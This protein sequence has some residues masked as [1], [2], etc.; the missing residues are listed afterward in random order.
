MDRRNRLSDAGGLDVVG[1]EIEKILRGRPLT[2]REVLRAAG[3]GAVAAVLAACGLGRQS[4]K[5]TD[6]PGGAATA[7][8]SVNPGKVTLLM[9]SLGD[10]T[11]DI[12]FSSGAPG[13]QVFGT[14][15]FGPFIASNEALEQIPGIASE[16]TLSDDGLTF[17][18]TIRE[19][20]KFQDGREVTMDD[21]LWSFQ[22]MFAPEVAALAAEHTWATIAESLRIEMSGPREITFG[23]DSPETILL[24]KKLLF[25]AESG[26]VNIM[27]KRSKLH[28]PAEEAAFDAAPIGTGP[29]KLVEHDRGNR[30][31]F[32]RF[33][34]YFFQPKYGA[35]EDRRV[36]FQRLEL[37]AVP[38]QSTRLAALQT[39]EADIAP[40]GLED[41]ERV[42]SFG[43]RLVFA[44]EAVFLHARIWGTMF[45][46]YPWHDKRVREALN[47]ATN[48]EL[49]RDELLGGT[50]A[51]E[52]KGFYTVTPSAMGYSP[53]L[54]PLPFDPEKA[55]QLIADA[56][57]PGGQGFAKIVLNIENDGAVA[58]VVEAAQV[59]AASWQEELGVQVE[60]RIGDPVILKD[61]RN[62]GDINEKGEFIWRTGGT[63]IDPTSKI[64]ELV[65]PDDPARALDNL[66]LFRLGVESGGIADDD[67]RNQALIELF[68][69]L[70]AEV[71]EVGIGYY[72][73]PWAVGPR[74][75]TYQPRQVSDYPANLHTITVED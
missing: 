39:G 55:R 42:E 43:G 18:V 62:S 71:P 58:R 38:E 29:M 28:D 59:V 63:R 15:V 17:K 50:E 7:G 37:I 36:R 12:V 2:R 5:A 44:K 31:A 3:L 75:K 23:V 68:K 67:E 9:P 33:D 24:L 54:D 45:P 19:G 46:Q 65:D 6:L 52:I 14:Q 56:G 64:F 70:R 11:F 32:E 49:I 60:A 47:Y 40:V 25:E 10:E 51:F 22:H 73:A 21:V 8:P 66:E 35:P 26:W 34:D 69:R 57:Y 61:R 4:P 20:V 30:M 74:I 16:W 72:N 41:K 13:E 48:K 27:P 53:D 1:P